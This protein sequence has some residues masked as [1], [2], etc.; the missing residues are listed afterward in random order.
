MTLTT[1]AVEFCGY[2]AAADSVDHAYRRFA[3][4]VKDVIADWPAVVERTVRIEA[5]EPAA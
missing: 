4:A 1:G 5:L 3:D 2:V